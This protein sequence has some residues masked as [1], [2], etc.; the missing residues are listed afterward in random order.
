MR[1]IGAERHRGNAQVLLLRAPGAELDWAELSDTPPSASTESIRYTRTNVH[2]HVRG[3]IRV[4]ERALY[5]EKRA[6]SASEHEEE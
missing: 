5:R 2:T 4:M 6:S 1:E 3:F